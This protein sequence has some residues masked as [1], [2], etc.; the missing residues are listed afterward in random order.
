M[1]MRRCLIYCCS[2]FVLFSASCQSAKQKIFPSPEGYDLNAPVVVKLNSSLDEISGILF[3]PKDSTVFGI[4]DEDGILFKIFINN[5][6]KAKSWHFG[7]KRDYEDVSL[8]DSTF[9]VLVSNGDLVGLKFK[10]DSVTTIKANFPNADKHEDEFETLYYDSSIKKLVMLCKE[11][12]DDKKK[13]ITAWSIDPGSLEYTPSAYK[14]DTKPIAAKFGENKIHFK[15]SGAAINPATDELYII[16]AINNLLVTADRKGDI[17]DMYE[18]DPK[19]FKQPE[20]ITFTPTGDL[21]ISNEAASTGSANILIF[22][23][24]KKGE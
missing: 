6:G 18:L 21:L 16:S 23:R 11:C 17:K 19:L 13:K 12:K 10:N 5:N 8:V 3:Y 9:Y 15:P 1:R 7:K 14:I 24:K 20:G 2:F 4:E 22:K